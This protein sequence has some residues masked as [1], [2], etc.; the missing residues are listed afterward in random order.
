MSDNTKLLRFSKLHSL[1]PMLKFRENFDLVIN[2]VPHCNIPR[3]KKLY[4]NIVLI[5]VKI[6]FFDVYKKK[7]KN[8]KSA[9][10]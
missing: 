6:F 5:T 2:N 10:N 4:M 9:Q 1:Q 3:K 8:E 7:K